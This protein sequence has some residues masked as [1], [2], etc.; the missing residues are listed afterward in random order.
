[1]DIANT[2][3]LLLV[4]GGIVTTVYT[5]IGGSNGIEGVLVNA[6]KG[7]DGK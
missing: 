6:M 7:V 3:M 4:S 1:M 5:N 2:P